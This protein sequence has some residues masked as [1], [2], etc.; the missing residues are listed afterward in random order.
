[1][2]DERVWLRHDFP[3]ADPPQAPGWFHCPAEAVPGWLQIGW[4][5]D[6]QGPPPAVNHAVAHL[7]AA[8]EQ[9]EAESKPARRP[10]RSRPTNEQPESE[11]TEPDSGEQSQE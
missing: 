2:A 4:V 5:E 8:A 3:D 11:T 6:P 1:M 10:R 7:V 9:A